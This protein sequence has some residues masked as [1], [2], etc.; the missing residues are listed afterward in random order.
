M[1]AVMSMLSDLRSMTGAAS[2][3]TSPPAMPIG[4]QT[5]RQIY[6]HAKLRT[7]MEKRLCRLDRAR[8]AFLEAREAERFVDGLF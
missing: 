8:M 6:K 2:V 1:A 7:R 4:I 5:P 3:A